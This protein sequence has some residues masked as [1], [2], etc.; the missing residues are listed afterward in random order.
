EDRPAAW[1]AAYRRHHSGGGLG[2]HG[3]AFPSQISERLRLVMRFT[4]LRR[5][6]KRNRIVKKLCD[7]RLAP[8]RNARRP[9]VTTAGSRTLRGRGASCGGERCAD[10]RC[11]TGRA[12]ARGG[13][14]RARFPAR[15]P[16][17]P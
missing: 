5:D 6:V 16:A 8:T 4:L 15:T 1:V 13:G 17:V 11:Q 9:Q 3:H 10:R 14:G 12:G 7:E 2:V